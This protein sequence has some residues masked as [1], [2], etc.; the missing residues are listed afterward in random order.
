MKKI[1][2][3]L[4]GIT[5]TA[6]MITPTLAK[7]PF[8]PDKT[9]GLHI[10]AKN[11]TF[12]ESQFPDIAFYYTPQIKWKEL[13]A[14]GSPEVLVNWLEKR[15]LTTNQLIAFDKNGVT[16]FT[17][18]LVPNKPIAEVT[19][20][21]HLY[22]LKES[23]V[24]LVE[25]DRLAKKESDKP[26]K[27]D[28]VS[29]L[30]GRRFPSFEVYDASGKTYQISEVIAGDKKPKLMIVF[31]IPYNY[32]FKAVDEHMEEAADPMAVL[33]AITQMES[34]EQHTAYL[35]L[36]EEELYNR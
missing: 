2:L 13:K 32:K 28:W 21:G 31:R 12:D 3:L 27:W 6:M 17:G 25:E 24:R 18:F 5:L 10:G 35:K 8:T 16:D 4:T 11:P 29:D 7:M 9:I 34:G 23:L 26:I 1:T 22:T 15:G 14:T 33:A 36:I 19:D 20:L 30:E